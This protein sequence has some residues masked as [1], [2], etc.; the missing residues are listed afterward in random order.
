MNRN[1][2]KKK[3]KKNRKEKERKGKKILRPP[4]PLRALRKGSLTSKLARARFALRR[5]LSAQE[6]SPA[7]RIR[8]HILDPF[9][10]WKY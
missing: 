10:L 1:G 4:G 7:V 3:K 5:A 6:P 9:I 2:K 8:R